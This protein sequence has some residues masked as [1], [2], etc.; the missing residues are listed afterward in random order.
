MM[1]MAVEEVNIWKER[2]DPY[3]IML[4]RHVLTMTFE[5]LIAH[6]FLIH[7]GQRRNRRVQQFFCCIFIRCFGNMFTEPLPGNSKG[8]H[9]QAHTV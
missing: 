7:H 8:I 6:C 3:L 4:T 5:E 1:I 9:I 2:S